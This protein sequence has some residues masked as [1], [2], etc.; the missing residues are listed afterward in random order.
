MEAMRRANPRLQLILALALCLRALV[1]DGFMPGHG[2]LLELCTPE[3]MRTVLVDSQTGELLDADP[4]HDGPACPWTAVFASA[5]LSEWAHVLGAPP[6]SAPIHHA[7][8]STWLSLIR[9]LPPARA[10]PFSWFVQSA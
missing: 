8:S 2:S 3:G 6:L 10:P 9:T 5:V 1:P 4:D 7:R